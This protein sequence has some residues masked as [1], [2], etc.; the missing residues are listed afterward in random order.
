MYVCMYSRDLEG[1]GSCLMSFTVTS[2]GSP[3]LCTARMREQMNSTSCET[4]C[5]AW[6]KGML[7]PT[8]YLPVT[9]HFASLELTTRPQFG[10]EVF[11]DGPKYL[12][13]LPLSWCTEDGRLV[14]DWMGG[15]PSPKAVQE[16]LSCQC[17][18]SCKIPLCSCMAN[19]LKCTDLSRL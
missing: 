15:L 4:G 7:I 2:R 5:S 19:G 14:I 1:N 16:L 8:S 11:N 9:T 17:S 18:R 3:V 10:N 6:R 12:R 13:L